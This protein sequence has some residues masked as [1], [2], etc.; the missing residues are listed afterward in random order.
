M[1]LNRYKVNNDLNKSVFYA[2]L[3]HEPNQIQVVLDNELIDICRDNLLL[4]MKYL[5]ASILETESS[6]KIQQ[7]IKSP[8]VLYVVKNT[9]KI[10]V[11]LTN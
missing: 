7:M 9:D 2:I 8:A 1:K 5:A 6:K 3:A 11:W 10:S 4:V